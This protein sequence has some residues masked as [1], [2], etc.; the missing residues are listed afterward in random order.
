MKIYFFCFTLISCFPIA[1]SAHEVGSY[2]KYLRETYITTIDEYTEYLD[3]GHSR[4][5]DG[6]YCLAIKLD[7]IIQANEL[8]FSDPNGSQ[9]EMVYYEIDDH[10]VFHSSIFKQPV[11]DSE[12]TKEM[13]DL[14]NIL[15]RANNPKGKIPY[16]SLYLAALVRLFSKYTVYNGSNEKTFDLSSYK[17]CKDIYSDDHQ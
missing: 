6:F 15:R 17:K 14:K 4:K 16:E 12:F 10:I 11:T 13:K 3:K 1:I 2:E 9:G 8:F 7:Y 5:T